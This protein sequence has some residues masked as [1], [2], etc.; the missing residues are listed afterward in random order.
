ACSQPQVDQNGGS[1]WRSQIKRRRVCARRYRLVEDSE[2]GANRSLVILERIEGQTDSR[3]EIPDVRIR[4]QHV[5]DRRESSR[6]QRIE[7][8]IER[9]PTCAD[10]VRR[11]LVS[12]TQIDRQS[13]RHLPVVLNVREEVNLAEIAGGGE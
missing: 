1:R 11:E 3:V 12:Q 4:R 10:G 2:A 13:R 9:N 7:D 8:H 6:G 5:L